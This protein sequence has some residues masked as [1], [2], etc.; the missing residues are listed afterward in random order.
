LA[1]LALAETIGPSAVLKWPNDV[2]LGDGQRKVAGLLAQSANCA[3]VVGIGLNVSTTPPELPVPTATSL[4][5]EGVHQQ[6]RASLLAGFLIA[7]GRRYDAWQAA[8][9][10]AER[11]GLAADYRARCATLGS[12]VS[13]ELMSHTIVGMALDIASNGELVVQPNDSAVP[14]IVAAGDITHLRGSSG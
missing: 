11:S 1:G 4:A 8:A 5:I 2:L 13:A 14:V 6:D 3:V 7:F 12:A 9:G 10:N